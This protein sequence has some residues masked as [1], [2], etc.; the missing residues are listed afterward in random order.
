LIKQTCAA[1]I[2][3]ARFNSYLLSVLEVHKTI[4]INVLHI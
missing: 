1:K 3:Y 2:K 4:W